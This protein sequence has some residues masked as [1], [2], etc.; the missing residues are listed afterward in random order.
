MDGCICVIF[1]AIGLSVLCRC[2]GS[3]YSIGIF[4][5]FLKNIYIKPLV[6]IGCWQSSLNKKSIKNTLRQKLRAMEYIFSKM[7]FFFLKIKEVG[8]I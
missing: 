5:I 6:A 1:L 2:T 8:I 7:F 3:D 4:N